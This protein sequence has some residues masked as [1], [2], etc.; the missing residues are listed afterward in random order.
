MRPTENIKKLIKNINIETNARADDVVLDEVVRAFE[1]SKK[2]ATSGVEGKESAIAQPSIWRIIVKSKIIKL[3]AT[4]AVVLLF[5]LFLVNILIE[6]FD[7]EHIV[8]KI[9]TSPGYILIN[10]Q[11]NYLNQEEIMPCNILP[12]PPGQF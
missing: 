11:N 10:Y 9:D 5:S 2:L 3:A 12:V 4:A 1:E 8:T 7:I 6:R